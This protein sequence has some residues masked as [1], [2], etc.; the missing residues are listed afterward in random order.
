[1]D[2]PKRVSIWM[3]RLAAAAVTAA[4][5]GYIPYRVYGSEGYVHYRQLETQVKE[6]ERGNATLAA[7][8]AHLHEEIQ[9]VRDDLDA[10]GGVARD[11]LGMVGPGEIVIKI[12]DAAAQAQP[13]AGK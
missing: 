8:N 7:Q 2:L 13:G 6:L 1:M 11:E 5:L 4:A 3:W 9:R 12:E 10:I